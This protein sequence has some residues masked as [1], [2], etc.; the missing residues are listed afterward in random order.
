MYRITHIR[1]KNLCSYLYFQSKYKYVFLQKANL[2]F[3]KNI[4]VFSENNT[5]VWG[6]Y[7]CFQMCLL[8]SWNVCF[9]ILNVC[10]DYCWNMSFAKPQIC[11]LSNSKYAFTETHIPLLKRHIS[12]SR[13]GIPDGISKSKYVFQNPNMLFNKNQIRFSKTHIVKVKRHISTF[14]LFKKSLSI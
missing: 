5:S 11:F 12:T 4:F 1:L 2:C 6:P 9:V 10:F 14:G 7:V 8:R 13:L 3:M